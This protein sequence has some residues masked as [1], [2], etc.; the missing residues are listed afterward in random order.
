VLRLRL[1]ST[2]C[3]LL[4]HLRQLALHCYTDASP[5]APAPARRQWRLPQIDS[6]TQHPT[7][8]NTQR[9]YSLPMYSITR[10]VLLL[11]GE[12]HTQQGRAH[13]RRPH[14][15]G[16]RHPVDL[17]GAKGRRAEGGCR[18]RTGVETRTSAAECECRVRVQRRVIAEC[19]F[20]VAGAAR[21]A[22]DR[23]ASPSLSVCIGT[24]TSRRPLF[25]PRAL[26]LVGLLKKLKNLWGCR[27]GSFSQ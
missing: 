14:P 20:V 5:P 13:S 18:V 3:C 17:R 7:T 27:W 8:P 6:N 9:D 2:S 11:V 22:V 4:Q 1:Y 25:M 24:G 23:L 26:M 10:F 15:A 16:T 21:P 19:T 12:A